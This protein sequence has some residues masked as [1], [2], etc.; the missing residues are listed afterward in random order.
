MVNDWSTKFSETWFTKQGPSMSS[1]ATAVRHSPE[2]ASVSPITPA[3]RDFSRPWLDLND[4]TVLVTGG[5][6]SFG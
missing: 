1:R 6:G 4:K 2:E 5:T 3:L